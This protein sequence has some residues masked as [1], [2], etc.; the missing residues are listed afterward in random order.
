M[1]NNNTAAH[2]EALRQIVL[3]TGSYAAWCMGSDEEKM[4]ARTDYV[5]ARSKWYDALTAAGLPLPA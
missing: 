5:N 2:I 3:S 4:N 1:N